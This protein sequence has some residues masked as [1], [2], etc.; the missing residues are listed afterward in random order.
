MYAKREAEISQLRAV[1]AGRVDAVRW[2]PTE[3]GH[4]W[5]GFPALGVAIVHCSWDVLPERRVEYG[6]V[7]T[8]A[9]RSVTVARD[10]DPYAALAALA[11]A[12]LDMALA[13]ERP[14]GGPALRVVRPETPS[15]AAALRTPHGGGA[16]LRPAAG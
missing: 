6:G 7:V 15:S 11:R 4:R 10:A 9:S 8:R 16:P 13:A 5:T 14:P 3:R 1:A 2:S 12:A